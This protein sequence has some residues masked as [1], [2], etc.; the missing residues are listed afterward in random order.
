MTE[1]T[2]DAQAHTEQETVDVGSTEQ[3]ETPEQVQDRVLLELDPEPDPDDLVSVGADGDP[4]E[5]ESDARGSVDEPS[6]PPLSDDL[7]DAYDVLRRDGWTDDDFE[8]LPEERLI[9]MAEHRRKMQADVDRKLREDDGP[10]DD[11]AQTDSED[12][13]NAEPDSDPPALDTTHL[14]SLSDYLGLD[15]AGKDLLRQF[16]DASVAPMQKLLQEQQR[17]IQNVQVSMLQLEVERARTELQSEHH[18]VRDVRSEEWQRV[19]GRMDKLAEEDPDKSIR[20]LMEDAVLLEFRGEIKQTAQDAKRSLN[21]Y[22]DQGQ[23]SVKPKPSTPQQQ[24]SS[25]S[26]REDAILRIL[27]SDDPDRFQR[28]RALGRR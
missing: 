13:H 15:D 8:A 28:A 6:A 5:G 21:G 19:L 27:D 24:F 14:D 18:Q 7:K 11:E 25:P 12:G 3:V 4:G 2:K 22:R 10:Q 9:A 26:E 23:P 20:D 17:M 1:E 16:Q